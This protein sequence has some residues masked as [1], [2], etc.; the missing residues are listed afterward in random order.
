M[1]SYHDQVKELKFQLEAARLQVGVGDSRY[2]RDDQVRTRYNQLVLREHQLSG[3]RVR[4][5]QDKR[6]IGAGSLKNAGLQCGLQPLQ[7]GIGG[8][9]R[10]HQ[11][12]GE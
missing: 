7:R 11:R 1:R 2:A 4:H 10:A 12:A 3:G 5:G 9:T 6:R 8:E